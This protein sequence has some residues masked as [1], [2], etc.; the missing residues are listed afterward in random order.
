MAAEKARATVVEQPGGGVTV[1]VPH[2]CMSASASVILFGSTASLAQNSEAPT[3]NRTV[4]LNH[5]YAVELGVGGYS[6]NGLTARAY[7][8]P[9]NYTLHDSCE[10]TGRSGS[11]DQ[12]N[13]AC[14]R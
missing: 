6:L 2:S 9:L 3:Q 14:V 1:R 5:V 10:T 11:W 12:S 13:S 8:L 4:N 7:E